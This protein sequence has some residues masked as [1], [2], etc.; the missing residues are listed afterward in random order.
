MKT[1]IEARNE[2]KDTMGAQIKEWGAAIVLQIHTDKQEQ[3][4]HQ[5]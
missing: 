4:I 2:I 3:Q 5:Q 1:Q